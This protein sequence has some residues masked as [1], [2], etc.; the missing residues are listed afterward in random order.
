MEV[1]TTEC[2]GF[3]ATTP[4]PS[5]NDSPAST[6]PIP[7]HQISPRNNILP[8]EQSL[9]VI[10]EPQFD[11]PTNYIYLTNPVTGQILS[12]FIA[13]HGSHIEIQP[14][15]LFRVPYPNEHVAYGNPYGTPQL[16][17]QPQELPYSYP[18]V[19][20]AGNMNGATMH[21]NADG[22][23]WYQCNPQCPL[24]GSPGNANPQYS[25]RDEKLNSRKEKLQKKLRE[26]KINQGR[27]T[28]SFTIPSHT[29]NQNMSGYM[30]QELS[31]F[32]LS[33][34]FEFTFLSFSYI[35]V[36]KTCLSFFFLCFFFAKH[37][38]FPIKM[39]NYLILHGHMFFMK[40][41]LL[42]TY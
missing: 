41:V 12:T 25:N 15:V 35:F 34:H 3:H 27:C 24:H 19:T 8:G 18:H 42:V 39:V 26:K 13:E 38:R 40:C 1:L 7:E 5:P 31:K 33:F 10:V 20:H 17:P 36:N 30:Q 29:S 32:Y 11:G 37:V 16:A 28:C 21:A 23:P 9:H 2:G 6:S 4:D 22:V 14:G